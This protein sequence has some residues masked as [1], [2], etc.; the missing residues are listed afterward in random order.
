MPPGGSVLKIYG[1]AVEKNLRLISG[2]MKNKE[3]GI[4]IREL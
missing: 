2:K 1:L 4:N 3:V